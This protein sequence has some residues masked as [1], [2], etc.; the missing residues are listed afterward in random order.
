M[1]E[2]ADQEPLRIIF[3]EASI[4]GQEARFMKMFLL[5]DD[6]GKASS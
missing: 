6:D 4:V 1:V 3:H 5:T 2:Q